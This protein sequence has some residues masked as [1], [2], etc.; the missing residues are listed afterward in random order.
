MIRMLVS[1]V[2]ALVSSA[3]GL[4][5][6]SWVLDDLEVTASGF[7]ITVVIFTVTAAVL[8]PFVMKVAMK[9]AQALLGATALVSTFVALLV[10]TLV[11]DGLSITGLDTWLIATL[12]VW[13]VTALASMLVPLLLVKAGV[14]SAR[15][16]R[17]N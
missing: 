5:V 14:E 6:S 9:N 15:E 12:L 17:A 1:A 13:L 3:I 10:T 7:V 2:V 8:Q 4:L 11:S 16:R